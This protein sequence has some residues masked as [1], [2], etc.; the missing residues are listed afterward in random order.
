MCAGMH[1]GFRRAPA[2]VRWV[3]ASESG[4][5]AM[6]VGGCLLPDIYTLSLSVFKKAG[7]SL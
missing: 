4:G 6:R 3:R 1:L 2:G 7:G 5:G